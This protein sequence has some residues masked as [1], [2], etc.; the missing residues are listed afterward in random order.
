MQSLIQAA[1][2][3]ALLFL[4]ILICAPPANA[5]APMSGPAGTRTTPYV[6]SICNTDPNVFFCEDF[7]DEATYPR[8]TAQ[9]GSWNNPA[10]AGVWG[11]AYNQGPGRV[12][13]T[14]STGALP[15][16]GNRIYR[17]SLLG[18]G[19]ANTAEGCLA[20]A[21]GGQACTGLSSAGKRYTDYYVRFQYYLSSGVTFPISGQDLKAF[22][23]Q[24]DANP[25][26]PS[27]DFQ[28]GLN[29]TFDYNCPGGV[30][31][32]DVFMMRRAWS[33]AD[34]G[35]SYNYPQ[36]PI[37]GN[38]FSGPPAGPGP[39]TDYCQP[40]S[41]GTAANN[42]NAVR[43]QRNRWYTVEMHFVLGTN[44]SGTAEMWIDGNLAYRF[45]PATG[46]GNPTCG[47]CSLGMGYFFITGYTRAPGTGG[48]AEFDNIVMST[49]PIGVFNVGGGTVKPMPPT[50]VNLSMIAPR[51]LGWLPVFAVVAGVTVVR[52]SRRPS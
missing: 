21:S 47:T 13:P 41:P 50:G 8:M 27:A 11:S 7:E 30:N 28:N 14:I 48:Y 37:R 19:A 20:R 52:R 4:M 33:Q 12:T 32:G 9:G 1:V 49:Q 35:T 23:T 42:A 16:S 3:S 36:A 17:L 18:G 29:F 2:L 38:M 22:F 6:E 31:Y 40:L 46:N 34:P 24:P 45:S 51:V 39:G 5:V 25:D 15:T 44:G 26:N 10:F 43:I